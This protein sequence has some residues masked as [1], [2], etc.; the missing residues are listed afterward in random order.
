MTLAVLLF[1]T[2]VLCRSIFNPLLVFGSLTDF[3][4]EREVGNMESSNPKLLKQLLS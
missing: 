4:G 2:N 1:E 3:Q